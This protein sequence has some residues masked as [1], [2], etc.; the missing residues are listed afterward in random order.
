MFGAFK[1]EYNKALNEGSGEESVAPKQ[2]AA[3]KKEATKSTAKPAAKPK[4]ATTSKPAAKPTAKSAAKTSAKSAAKKAASKSP[5][6]VAKSI[7][8]HLAKTKGMFAAFKEEFD[9]ASKED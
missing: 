6:D 7:G 8:Q 3:P 9:K 4:S 1:D 2:V 5:D